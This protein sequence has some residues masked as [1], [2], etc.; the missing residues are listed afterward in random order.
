MHGTA[1]TIIQFG[2]KIPCLFNLSLY[3]HVIT[4]FSE[5]DFHIRD[6]VPSSLLWWEQLN[7]FKQSA[8]ENI[9]T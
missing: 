4:V 6:V 8:Y 7:V 3:R 2:Q 9:W 5:R 1:F